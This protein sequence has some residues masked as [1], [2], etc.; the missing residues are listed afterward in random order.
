MKLS[1]IVAYLNHLDTLSVKD[2]IS[3]SM[4]EV[5]KITHTVQHSEIQAGDHAAALISIQD[6]LET[7]LKQYEEELKKL[8]GDVQALIEQKEPE[9]FLESTTRYQENMKFDTPDWII[10]RTRSLDS[11]TE[12]LLCARLN[13]HTSWQYPGMVLRPAHCPGLES[14]VALDPLYLVDTH[15]DLL[16]PIRTLFTPA[17]Q[18]RLRYYVIE[19]YMSD[20]IF[21]NLPQTQFGFVYAFHYFEYKPLEIIRQYLDEIFVLLRPG[22]TFLFSFNDCDQ[23]RSVG[24]VEHYSSCYTPGRLIR[25]HIQSMHYQIVYD[26]RDRN[27]TAWL[28]LRKPGEL[29]SI[30]GGQALASVFRLPQYIEE[31]KRL[32]DEAKRLEEEKSKEQEKITVQ[33]LFNELDLDK[34]IHLAEIL[35]VDIS[36]DKTKREFNIKKV[37]R[38]IAAHLEST[39]YSKKHLRRLFDTQVIDNSPQDLYNALDLDQL[40]NLAEMLKIDISEDTTRYIFDFNKVRRTI[41]IHLESANYSEEHRRILF[42]PKENP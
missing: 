41:S 7:S 14:L 24:S 8:R 11:E 39:N 40:I 28:E 5:T 33:D 42:N 23:W 3:P 4:A 27:N 29:D 13:A 12:K 6:N 37:R 36:Q 1:H 20:K 25:Q 31:D 15:Q 2:A 16:S 26:Y 30:R 34:L 19:E 17:Y 35:N 38:T 9:Y 22:G 32:M 21:C 10:N 18:R